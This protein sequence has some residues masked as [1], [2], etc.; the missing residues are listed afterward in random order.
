[1]HV[2]LGRDV[3]RARLGRAKLA[4]MLPADVLEAAAAA[5]AATPRATA[6]AATAAAAARMAKQA[7]KVKPE[8]ADDD[9]D[10]DDEDD[11]NEE[12]NEEEKEEQDDEDED[13]DMP[14]KALFAS[15]AKDGRGRF[16]KK[17]RLAK[18][19]GS[20]RSCTPPKLNSRTVSARLHEHSS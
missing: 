12:D 8:P 15:A 5:A 3:S 20:F 7:A 11:D 4:S 14:V 13:G 18:A 10:D 1:V 17:P 6:K 2:A 16:A 9:D 19:G